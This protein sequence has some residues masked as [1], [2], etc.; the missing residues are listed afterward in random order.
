MAHNKL[1][2]FC[3]K[4]P[5]KIAEL[6]K[7][8]EKTDDP[9]RAS[10]INEIF[11]GIFAD[12]NLEN[13][14]IPY[15]ITFKQREYLKKLEKRIVDEIIKV[16]E[17]SET[18]KRE[19]KEEAKRPRDYSKTIKQNKKEAI[20]EKISELTREY[21]QPLSGFEELKYPF[22]R[23]ILMKEFPQLISNYNL[24]VDNILNTFLDEDFTEN[25][26]KLFWFAERIQ[27]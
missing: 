24:C 17:K 2:S 12:K 20:I 26:C 10:Q 23:I 9:I 14:K 25:E 11:K 13:A 4:V 5:K 19:L 8:L 16:I 1:I 27:E 7:E 6:R 3:L 22:Q 21:F 15:E 18:N